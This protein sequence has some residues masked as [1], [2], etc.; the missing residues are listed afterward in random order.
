MLIL[1]EG[2]L[3]HLLTDKGK[4]PVN[5]RAPETLLAPHHLKWLSVFFPEKA[6]F[7]I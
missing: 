2:F 6:L 5:G 7:V 4:D 3:L 1:G